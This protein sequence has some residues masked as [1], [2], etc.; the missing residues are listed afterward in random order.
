MS[1]A[2]PDARP[3]LRPLEVRRATQGAQ[4]GLVL[5]DPLGLAL[6]A[7]FV[8]DGLLPI[9]AKMDG[10]RTLAEI[11]AELTAEH[12][13]PLPAGFLAE[14]VGQLDGNLLLL[15]PRFRAAAEA[16]ARAFLA[17]AVRPARHAGSPGYPA[18]PHA[19]RAALTDIVAPVGTPS[20]PP[21]RGLVAP[22]IDLQRGRQ[23]YAASYRRLAA[24]APPDLFVV[25]GTGHRGPAAPVTGL[26]LDWETPLGLVR[27]DR[28]FL[29]EVHARIGEPDPI[30][31]LLHRDEHSLEFQVLFLK[32][33]WPQ[34]DF[35]VAC[36]LTGALPSSCGDPGHEEY[37]QRLLRAFGDAAQARGRRICYVAGA[38]LAHLGP[39]HGD[40]L[41]VDAARCERLRADELE[42]LERLCLGDPGGFHQMVE[43]LGN[44]DRVCGLS[45]IYLTATLAGGQAELLHYGQAVA[46]DGSQVVSFCSVAFG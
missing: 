45:P 42:R 43:S 32:H 18:E 41:P 35:E 8:P 29:A 46:P 19:L 38:D 2:E 28:K 10:S 33:L 14:L 24:A 5:V 31:A 20:L 21:P 37:A 13:Q 30:D 34:A 44:P 1:S 39:V 9:V 27:S 40:P 23:G 12:G 4:R 22:H 6:G 17:Q 26:A 36:F 25:F 15:T 11:E 7:A 3:A 16:S